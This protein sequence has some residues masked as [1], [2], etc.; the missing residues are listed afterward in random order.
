LLRIPLQ[1][2][3]ARLCREVLLR[4]FVKN[5][6]EIFVKNSVE[7]GKSNKDPQINTP[8]ISE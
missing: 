4:G 3:V 2:F 7:T 8:L 6:V 1:G 5:S